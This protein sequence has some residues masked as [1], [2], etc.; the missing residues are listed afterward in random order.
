MAPKR[1][2]KQTSTESSTAALP[3]SAS[4]EATIASKK[5]KF[6]KVEQKH[7]QELENLESLKWKC[8]TAERERDQKERNMIAEQLEDCVYKICRLIDHQMMN[9][10]TPIS[11]S[12]SSASSSSSSSSA[13]APTSTPDWKQSPEFQQLVKSRY[14][15][16]RYIQNLCAYFNHCDLLLELLPTGKATTITGAKICHHT[17]DI[18]HAMGHRQFLEQAKQADPSWQCSSWAE[19]K[20]CSFGCAKIDLKQNLIREFLD[21][22]SPRESTCGDYRKYQLRYHDYALSRSS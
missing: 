10:S 18:A 14:H 16:P 4:V 11:F 2:R 3:S 19:Q 12:S 6:E 5:A 22:G 1:K 8:R 9:S 20:E 15:Y 13:T 7:K 17:C 21:Y